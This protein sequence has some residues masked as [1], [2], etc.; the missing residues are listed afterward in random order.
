MM[1]NKSLID[2]QKQLNLINESISS[3]HK[4]YDNRLKTLNSMKE[5]TEQKLKWADKDLD[6]DKMIIGKRIIDIS[7]KYDKNNTHHKKLISLAC[8][9][10]VSENIKMKREYFGIKDYS[11]YYNQRCDCK[12]GYGPRHGHITFSVGLTKMAR[13]TKLSRYYIECA[14]YYLKNI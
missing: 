10:L 4:E 13:E 9:D 7:D 3:T 1:K 6:I 8:E 2:I 12:Y 11:G 5:Q 14:L